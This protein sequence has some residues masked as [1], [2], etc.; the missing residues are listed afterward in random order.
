MKFA[1]QAVLGLALVA[2]HP[3]FAAPV[4]ASA[5]A[6]ASAPASAAAS[7]PAQVQ[8]VQDLLGAMQAEKILNGVA[9]RSRYA[10]EAQRQGV[11][12]KI[13]KTPPAEIHRRL[14]PALLP[15]ISTD[16][17]LEMTRF[18]RTPYGQQVI[19]QRYNSAAQIQMPGMRASVPAQEQKER[20]RAAYVTA[21]KALTDA[22]PAIEREA[23]KLLQQI[24]KEK[25]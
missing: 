23:F 21:S 10:S 8:A 11:Y 13:A 7:A 24:D 17:A 12:A 5:P 22:Q 20:K 18:Y 4:S 19:A 14:A 25:R 9:A 16:T 15:V 6:P 2:S 1:V 3:A